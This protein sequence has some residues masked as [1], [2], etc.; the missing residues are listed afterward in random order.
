MSDQVT[1]EA[2]F[3]DLEEYAKFSAEWTPILNGLPLLKI[4]TILR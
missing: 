3:E 1:W 4:L 2:G